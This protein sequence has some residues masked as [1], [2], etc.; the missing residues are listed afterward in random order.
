MVIVVLK[1]RKNRII[2]VIVVLNLALKKRKKRNV[3]SAY[4]SSP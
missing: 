1:T 2:S 3:G 4:V